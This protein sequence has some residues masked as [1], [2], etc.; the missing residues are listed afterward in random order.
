MTNP[1]NLLDNEVH[2]ESW[3][4][5]SDDNVEEGPAAGEEIDEKPD[6][7]AQHHDSSYYVD[8]SDRQKPTFKLH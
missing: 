6:L 5:H 1:S 4:E 3:H 7:K 2:N 8:N